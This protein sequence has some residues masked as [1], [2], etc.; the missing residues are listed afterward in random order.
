MALSPQA[1]F[2]VLNRTT[3]RNLHLTDNYVVVYHRNLFTDPD[4]V[5]VLD[6][7]C[8][9][10]GLEAC[11]HRR[12]LPVGQTWSF[13]SCGDVLAG[14]LGEFN[15]TLGIGVWDL[16]TGTQS[17]ILASETGTIRCV[18]FPNPTTIISGA[19]DGSVIVWDVPSGRRR[20]TLKEGHSNT[21]TVAAAETDEGHPS[22]VTSLKSQANLLVSATRGGTAQ[23]WDLNSGQ[24]IQTLT[25]H[26]DYFSKV[27]LNANRSL[28]ATG[29]A[30]GE[31]RIWDLK[32]GA[33]IATCRDHTWVVTQFS[34]DP[35][36][37][38]LLVSASADGW[39]RTWEW[40]TGAPVR[41]LWT[42]DHSAGRNAI[43]GVFWTKELMV[44]ANVNGLLRAYDRQTHQPRFDLRVRQGDI[45]HV[46]R[47]GDLLAVVVR[48]ESG[49]HAVELYDVSG[50]DMEQSRFVNKD[51]DLAGLSL[52]MNL[53]LG[54]LVAGQRNTGGG[55]DGD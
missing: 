9:H 19:S 5:N 28:L 22:A 42:G 14:A 20:H 30:K 29:Q 1:S 8:Q 38:G 49:K 51:V 35:D 2:L 23:I 46:A 44:T 24:C 50:L 40:S 39:I 37:T 26:V 43:R 32:S 7:R 12:R 18:L 41:A 10:S 53:T 47:R 48:V 15:A 27:E 54:C 13:E 21:H 25:G 45:F 6:I 31:I 33:C 52:V 3:I 11:E 4:E 36:D 34:T 17:A 16:K 55:F